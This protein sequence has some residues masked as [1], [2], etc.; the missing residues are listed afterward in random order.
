MFTRRVVAIAAIAGVL[1]CAAVGATPREGNPAGGPESPS[2]QV[3]AAPRTRLA[4]AQPAAAPQNMALLDAV[5]SGN[6]PFKASARHMAVS[7]GLENLSN[8]ILGP[9]SDIAA[10]VTDALSK[11]TTRPLSRTSLVPFKKSMR[12]SLAERR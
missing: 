6:S 11:P 12:F 7:V 10:H 9:Y 5:L 1:L 4:D 3:A 2:A 8:R